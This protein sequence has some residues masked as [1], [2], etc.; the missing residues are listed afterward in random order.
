MRLTRAEWQLVNRGEIE[1]LANVIVARRLIARS[2][3]GILRRVGFTA[4]NATV[5]DR[6][7]P[8]VIRREQ[9]ADLKGSAG[10][11]LQGMK[12]AVSN[13]AAPRNRAEC[14]VRRHACGRIYQIRVGRG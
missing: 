2:A 10:V 5:V 4:A 13:V 11:Y 8:H 7:R 1:H 3:E 9:K 6:M 12:S 14:R